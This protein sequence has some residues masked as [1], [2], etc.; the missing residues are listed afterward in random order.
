MALR[1]RRLGAPKP[2]G[3]YIAD[4]LQAPGAD[5]QL[6][7]TAWTDIEPTTMFGALPGVFPCD[8]LNNPRLFTSKVETH[9]VL[10]TTSEAKGSTIK[11]SLLGLLVLLCLAL[12]PTLT[13]ATD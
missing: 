4:P 7:R 5:E 13:A 6:A 9:C 10:S 12:F 8:L 3:P 1:H 11:T 2:F